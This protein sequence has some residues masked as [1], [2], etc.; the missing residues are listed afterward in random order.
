[1]SHLRGSMRE[2]ATYADQDIAVGQV[3]AAEKAAR[4]GDKA[5][6]IRH[7]KNVGKWTLDVATKIGVNL[8]SEAI[9]KAS[10]L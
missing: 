10:G 8:A 2:T 5:T 3:A 7:L 4:E 9:K 1:L 6:V